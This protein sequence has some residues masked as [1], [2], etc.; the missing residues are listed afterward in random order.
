MICGGP[1]SCTG[2]G[3]QL[4]LTIGNDDCTHPDT[5][6]EPKFGEV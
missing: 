3:V 6:D 2:S 5:A 4:I 1:E